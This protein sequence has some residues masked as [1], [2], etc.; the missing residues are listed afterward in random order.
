M[1]VGFY[2][3]PD[4]NGVRGLEYPSKSTQ[5]KTRRGKYEVHKALSACD[6]R[7]AAVER[8][9]GPHPHRQL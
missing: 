6:R 9:L 2:H 7:V 8:T 3:S 5:I 1:K 4:A